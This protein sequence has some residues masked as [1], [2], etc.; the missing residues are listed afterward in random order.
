MDKNSPWKLAN[1]MPCLAHANYSENSV[2]LEFSF[3]GHHPFPHFRITIV[4]SSCLRQRQ[5][6]CD[7]NVG[8]LNVPNS[9]SVPHYN[10]WNLCMKITTSEQARFRGF[11]YPTQGRHLVRKGWNKNQT[12]AVWLWRPQ[13]VGARKCLLID[14]ITALLPSVLAGGKKSNPKVEMV[15]TGRLLRSRVSLQLL[16]QCRGLFWCS[17]LCSQMEIIVQA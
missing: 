8:S 9:F 17:D 1:C 14:Y 2:I 5:K 3:C 4:L 13:F 12:V 15:W 10:L 16:G 7:N 11:S 6:G